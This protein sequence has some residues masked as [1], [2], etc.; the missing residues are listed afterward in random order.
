MCEI[1][2]EIE[3]EK[4]ID[5]LPQYG[6][7]VDS[8]LCEVKGDNPVRCQHYGHC[9]YFKQ[10]EE[11]LDSDFLVLPHDYL[12]HESKLMS[13]LPR[14][15]IMV[16]DEAFWQK[17]TDIEEMPLE[18]I[19]N[20]VAYNAN[21]N[22]KVVFSALIESVE[23]GCFIKDEL[24]EKGL[25]KDVLLKA[26]KSIKSKLLSKLSFNKPATLNTEIRNLKNSGHNKYGFFL[27]ILN[28]LILEWDF[29]WHKIQSVTFYWKKTKEEQFCSLK[30]H[31]IRELVHTYRW[32][33][34]LVIDGSANKLLIEKCLGEPFKMHELA[35]KRKSFIRQVYTNNMSKNR[36]TRCFTGNDPDKNITDL[37]CIIRRIAEPGKKVVVFT[38]KELEEKLSLPDN[39]EIEHFGNIRGLDKYKD[40]DEAIIIGRNQP[41]VEAVESIAR[42]IFCDDNHPLTPIKSENGIHTFHNDRRGGYTTGGDNKEV[43]ESYHPDKR[44]DIILKQIREEETIQAISR[45]RDIWQDGKK[46]TIIS[47][48]PLDIEVDRLISFQDLLKNGDEKIDIMFKAIDWGTEVLPLTG[49]YLRQTF[50]ELWKSDSSWGV[51]KNRLIISIPDY[52]SKYYPGMKLVKF[53]N[54]DSRA[55]SFSDVITKLDIATTQKKLQHILGSKNIEIDT[56]ENPLSISL[57]MVFRSKQN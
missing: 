25:S 33:P 4:I 2:D 32:V 51:Y 22:E 12:V 42:C 14:P 39:C 37:E 28:C 31:L 6:I 36:L 5:L 34:K 47:K 11:A 56:E 49:K 55:K 3:G 26:K 7:S 13:A 57:L 40:F 19:K 29:K 24:R 30:T 8:T 9:Q 44:C 16:I 50:P 38:Y 23:A 46:I 45:L 27:K 43:K 15:K 53:R 41:P 35:V 17:F 52:L 48:L 54:L 18:V 10:F 1:K 20:F 21:D